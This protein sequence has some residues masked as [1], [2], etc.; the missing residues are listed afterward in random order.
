LSFLATVDF[1]TV[2]VW[3]T[4][5]LVAYYLLFV[6]HLAM[7]RVQFAAWMP[8]P[9]GITIPSEIIKGWATR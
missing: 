1:T 5:G 9:D 8:K 2:E 3:T 4:R 6:M 7:R